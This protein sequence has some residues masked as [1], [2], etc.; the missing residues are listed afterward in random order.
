[1]AS[2]GLLKAQPIES[3]TM[4]VNLIPASIFSIYIL[5]LTFMADFSIE[6]HICHA[7]INLLFYEAAF[8]HCIMIF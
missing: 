2:R 1:M 8:K 4:V 5:L 7:H 6:V 3:K